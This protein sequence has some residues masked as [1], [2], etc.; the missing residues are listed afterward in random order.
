MGVQA[1]ALPDWIF[2]RLT[3]ERPAGTP[4]LTSVFSLIGRDLRVARES[5][6]TSEMDVDPQDEPAPEGPEQA[7]APVLQELHCPLPPGS[8]AVY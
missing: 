1:P 6:R 5:A 3:G 4:S 2:P 7:P 8:E